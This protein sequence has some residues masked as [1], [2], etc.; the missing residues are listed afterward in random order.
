MFK[1]TVSC[2][3]L[4]SLMS[5]FFVSC[6]EE[7]LMIPKET[8]E[9]S[10]GELHNEFVKAFLKVRPERSTA[11]IDEDQDYLDIFVESSREVCKTIGIDAELNRDVLDEFLQLNNTMREAG[12]W[13]A[14]NLTAYSPPEVINHLR[15]TGAISVK[16]AQHIQSMLKKIKDIS[17]YD[18]KKDEPNDGVLLLTTT[19]IGEASPFVL[20]VKDVLENSIALWQEVLDAAGEELVGFDPNDPDMVAAWWKQVAKWAGSALGDT[21]VFVITTG[22][23]WTPPVIVFVTTFASLAAYEAF[24][25]R[26]W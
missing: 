2:I 1:R 13:D 24:N 23:T 15:D 21:I 22:L 17:P 7:Q 12:I 26:G 4:V 3:L 9:M 20:E 11:R 16:D 8:A 6:R 25:E 10:A 18:I 19:E 5:M 14:F